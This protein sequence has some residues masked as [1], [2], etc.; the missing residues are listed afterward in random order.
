MKYLIT[1]FAAFAAF[2]A[3]ALT[4]ALAHEGHGMEGASHWHATDAVGLV[5]GLLAVGA[6]VW[7]GGRGGK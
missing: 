2:A 4:P 5:V 1:A 6:M 3:T 7:F